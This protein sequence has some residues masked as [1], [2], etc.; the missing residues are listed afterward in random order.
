MMTRGSSIPGHILTTYLPPPRRKKGD[1]PLV[2]REI[3]FKPKNS[4]ATLPTQTTCPPALMV[5]VEVDA[6]DF[7]PEED[8]LMDDE[9][10]MDDGN[11]NVVPTPTPK[12]KSTIMGDTSRLNDGGLDNTKRRGF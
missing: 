6:I 10:K 9:T 8:D 4:K 1:G 2:H 12:L 5:G 3:Y 7:E 11:A